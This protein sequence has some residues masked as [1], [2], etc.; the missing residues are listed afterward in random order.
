M[1]IH[2]PSSNCFFHFL[3]SLI[4]L[5]VDVIFSIF[6]ILSFEHHS[7]LKIEIC[8]CPKSIFFFFRILCVFVLHFVESQSFFADPVLMAVLVLVILFVEIRD[9]EPI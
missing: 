5:F 1:S 8:Q 9:S 4:V 7:K 2:V 6:L 3:C